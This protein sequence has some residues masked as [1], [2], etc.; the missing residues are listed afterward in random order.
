[1]RSISSIEC[2]VAATSVRR[3]KK[4]GG[5]CLPRLCAD[6]SGQRG[7]GLL[8]DLR[9]SNF[10]VHGKVCED[11]AVDVDGGLLEAVHEHAVA[12]SE[13]ADRGVDAG[14]PQHAEI[15]LF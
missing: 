5:I 9:K 10:V 8:R 14:D 11:L 1:M 13:L 12:H 3:A 4:E 15:A 6:C 7:F 2:P